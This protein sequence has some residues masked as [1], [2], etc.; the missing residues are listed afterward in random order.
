MAVEDDWEENTRNE[1]DYKE[2]FM[3]DLK[4]QWDGYKPVARIQL[5]KNDSPSAWVMVNCKVCKSVIV[6]YYL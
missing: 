3:C 6:L 1:L 5:V 2:D 4:L